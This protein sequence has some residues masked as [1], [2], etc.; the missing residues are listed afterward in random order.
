MGYVARLCAGLACASSAVLTLQV[1]PNEAWAG[2][3][4]FHSAGVASQ[5]GN[6]IRGRARVVDGDTLDIA[7]QRVRLEGIDAPEINQSCVGN[8]ERQWLA[9][10]AAAAALSR[11]VRGH[12]V[13]CRRTGYDV[14]GRA[15][16]NCRAGDRDLNAAMIEGGLAW[17]FRKYS[18]TYVREERRAREARLGVWAHTC[19]TAWDYRARRWK[20]VAQ[21]APDGCAIKGNITRNGRIYHMPWS[22]WYGRTRIE[23]AKGERWFCN[24]RQALAAGWRPALVR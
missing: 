3:V 1:V 24:E 10:R 21:K 8:S 14:Y 20:A 11:W 16:A 2:D 13:T 18:R 4:A 12:A 19:Q 17:A 22:P 5:V 9:G 7:G 6:L 15:L 23:V